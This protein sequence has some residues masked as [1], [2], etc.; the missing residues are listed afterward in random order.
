M[1]DETKDAAPQWE[2]P[3]PAFG[4]TPVTL[5]LVCI[6]SALDVLMDRSRIDPLEFHE[7]VKRRCA[8]LKIPVPTFATMP[9]DEA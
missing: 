3:P 7:A 6:M 2:P 9:E 1:A 5:S 4:E 8:G